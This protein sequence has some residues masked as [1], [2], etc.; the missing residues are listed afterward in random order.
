DAL[1]FG[2]FTAGA[3]AGTINQAGT[4]T[5]GVSLVGAASAGRQPGSLTVSGQPSTSYNFT[6]PAPTP[7]HGSGGGT[8]TVGLSF[9]SGGASR[10]LSGSGNDLVVVNGLLSVNANQAVGSYTGSY[11]VSVN[12]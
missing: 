7:L 6:L 4:V 1:T 11:N 3:S 12:Y 8:M 10:S 2:S 5:G 9:A